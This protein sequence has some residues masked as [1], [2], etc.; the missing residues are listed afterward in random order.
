MTNRKPSCI[1]KYAL[2]LV[3]FTSVLFSTT[4]FAESAKTLQITKIDTHIENIHPS[5]WAG[6]TNPNGP[7]LFYDFYIYI[8]NLRQ[9]IR[10]IKEVR[11]ENKYGTYWIIEHKHHQNLNKGYIGGGLWYD[12]TI[13]KNGA[14]L[15]LKDMKA[16]ITLT[17]KTTVEEPFSIPEPGALSPANIDFV[18][19]ETYRGKLT[20]A[21]SPALKLGIINS[22]ALVDNTFTINFTINDQRVANGILKF[23]DQNKKYVGETDDFMNPVTGEVLEFLNDGKEFYTDERANT[24]RINDSQ[25]YYEKGRHSSD[26]H[27]VE[28]VLYDG[29]QFASSNNPD[30]YL[31][32]SRSELFGL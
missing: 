5:F 22:A 21:H 6:E 11:I 4:M 16:I 3:F 17:N 7:R 26:A 14:I 10:K 15:T 27:Y 25:I 9:N 23:Y 24:F 8:D 1:F 28:L 12:S 20:K 31:Y 30:D 18:Y 29:A 32:V 19:C 13:S 2:L